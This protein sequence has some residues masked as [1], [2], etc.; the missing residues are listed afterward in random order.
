MTRHIVMEFGGGLGDIFYQLYQRGAYNVLNTLGPDDT[1]RILLVTHNPYA[2]ELFRWHPKMSQLTV[3]MPGYW[4]PA[5]DSAMRA[6]LDLPAPG[7]NAALPTM[8]GPIQ[9]YPSPD[10]ES[11][12]APLQG[13]RYLVVAPSAGTPDRFIPQ[14]LLEQ[15]LIPALHAQTDLPLVMAGRSYA[16]PLPDGTDG[17]KE[18]QWDPHPGVINLVDRLSVPGTASLVQQAA[19]VITAHSALCLLGWLEYKPQLLL[20]PP[21][22][23][24]AHTQNGQ[25]DQWMFAA[26]RANTT[27]STFTSYTDYLVT[28]FLQTL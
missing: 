21:T 6:Q 23:L 1:A 26:H 11:V 16:R 12:L 3:Q 22:V 18:Y 27:H 24:T 10:D 20:Y 8:E 7:A 13:T 19:G 25:F 17:R 14:D 4:S 28:R 2:P 5:D 9:F 15:Q